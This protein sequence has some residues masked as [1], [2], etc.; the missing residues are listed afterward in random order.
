MP[1]VSGIGHPARGAIK[2]ADYSRRV[3]LLGETASEITVFV[4][5]G[6]DGVGVAD[7][8]STNVAREGNGK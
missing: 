2:M 8:P 3:V 5:R 7:I 1:S 4:V 6:G